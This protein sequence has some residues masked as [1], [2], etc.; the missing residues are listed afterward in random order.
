VPYDQEQKEKYWD[1]REPIWFLIKKTKRFIL[2]KYRK[3]TK[4]SK[5]WNSLEIFKITTLPNLKSYVLQRF[6]TIKL[7]IFTII[8][9]VVNFS[10]WRSPP[11][12]PYFDPKYE[13][14]NLL[15]IS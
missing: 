10:H 11:S 12:F 4:L 1:T 6:V 9:R 5:L 14:N 7:R 15:Q 8:H 13:K 3:M 2:F